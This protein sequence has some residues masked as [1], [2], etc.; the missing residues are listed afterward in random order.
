M[1]T[2]SRYYIYSVV[3]FVLLM[4]AIFFYYQTYSLNSLY[5]FHKTDLNMSGLCSPNLPSF[6]IYYADNCKTCTSTV[7]SFQ[8]VTSLFGLWGNKTFY[9]GYFCAW[10]FNISAYNNNVTANLPDSAVS[11]FNQIGVNRVPLIV[12]N[13]KYYKVGG[14]ANNQTAYNDIL[15][16][17]CLSVNESLP[18]CS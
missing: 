8:N 10:E 7:D 14:F 11:I 12:F 6:V 18:Q 3:I 17:I 15:K 16:Y 5:S 2:K 4:L 1:L 9:S 13:G